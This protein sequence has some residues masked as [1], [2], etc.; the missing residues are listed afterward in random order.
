MG[1]LNQKNLGAAFE[2]F[3]S[4]Q[5]WTIENGVVIVPPNPDNQIQSTV[6]QETITLPRT[7]L[8]LAWIPPHPSAD[9]FT[10]ISQ[11]HYTCSQDGMTVPPLLIHNG[12]LFDICERG[13]SPKTQW[14][15][16]NLSRTIHW[17]ERV[18]GI[19]LSGESGI[20]AHCSLL[21]G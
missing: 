16:C 8:Y 4:K 19:T 10:R 3:V 1:T 11:G 7:L 12:M 20:M 18:R 5:G 6:V 17:T 15:I 13:G 14:T 2:A 9:S 21:Y